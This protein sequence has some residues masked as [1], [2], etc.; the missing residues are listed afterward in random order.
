MILGIVCTV[1]I[2]AIALYQTWAARRY[3]EAAA[4]DRD[5]MLRFCA[6]CDAKQR[7]LVDL[8]AVVGRMHDA[9]CRNDVAGMLAAIQDG[10]RAA[11]GEGTTIAPAPGGPS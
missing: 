8:G 9:A 6:I 11:Q 1:A 5:S 2:A 3:R 4:I 10:I 7:Q